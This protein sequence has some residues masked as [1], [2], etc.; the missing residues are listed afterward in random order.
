MSN[1]TTMDNLI[2][3]QHDESTQ[4]AAV[5]TQDKRCF[6]RDCTAPVQ[7][8]TDEKRALYEEYDLWLRILPAMPC[9]SVRRA[10]KICHTLT[11]RSIRVNRVGTMDCLSVTIDYGN[12]SVEFHGDNC[13]IT[14]E[15]A[16][17]FSSNWR[18]TDDNTDEVI[19]LM[20]SRWSPNNRWSHSAIQKSQ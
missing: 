17:D 1:N 13:C 5:D 7:C 2:N 16:P 19:E 8:D 20:L 15:N 18:L 9:A 10:H 6:H 12:V 3:T 4:T 14:D 11:T